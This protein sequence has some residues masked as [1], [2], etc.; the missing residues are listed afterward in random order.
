MDLVLSNLQWFICHKTK[1]NQTINLSSSLDHFK[2]SKVNNIFRLFRYLCL[3]FDF[4]YKVWFRDIFFFFKDTRLLNKFLFTYL[5][6]FIIFW[7]PTGTLCFPYL[8]LLFLPI[9]LFHTFFYYPYKH[10]KSINHS[11]FY[12]TLGLQILIVCI[13]FPNHYKFLASMFTSSLYDDMISQA[14]NI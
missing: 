9:F 3:C 1:P 6:L 8:S 13:K 4:Y 2:K 7:F 12:Y 10:R 11:F 14:W 5:Q